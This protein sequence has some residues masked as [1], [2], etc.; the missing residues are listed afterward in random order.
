MIIMDDRTIKEID[1]FNHIKSILIE[2]VDLYKIRCLETKR[3]IKA[4]YR[5]GIK[6]KPNEIFV[7]LEAEINSHIN[8][9]GIEIINIGVKKIQ[10]FIMIKEMNVLELLLKDKD[11]KKEF[12][13]RLK[14]NEYFCALNLKN[15][16]YYSL[17]SIVYSLDENY[18]KTELKSLIQSN[19][20]FFIRKTLKEIAILDEP[21]IKLLVIDLE[22]YLK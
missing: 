19:I 22:N 18:Q 14:Q 11:L 7:I 16:F 13:L 5:A 12:T 1:D 3:K 15:D 4:M 8:K 17:Y 9:I 2:R 20:E 6:P 10:E 21:F